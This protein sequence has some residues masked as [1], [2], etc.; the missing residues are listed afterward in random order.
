LASKFQVGSWQVDPAALEITRDEIR[1]KVNPRSMSVLVHLANHAGDVVTNAELLAAFWRGSISSTNAVHKAVAE[2]RAAFGDQRHEA[3][4][5]ETVTK[6]GY[7]LIAPVVF[8]EPVAP[9]EAYLGA[10]GHS[11]TFAPP[12]SKTVWP[13][14]RRAA[15][16][17]MIAVALIGSALTLFYA[18][19]GQTTTGQSASAKHPPNKTLA[20]LRF[21][22]V[23]DS[24][25]NE[26]L[27]EGIATALISR[28]GK[29]PSLTVIDRDRAFLHSIAREPAQAITTALNA[30]YVLD[31][32]VQRL[33]DHL[34]VSVQLYAG[35]TGEKQYAYSN[36]TPLERI[37]T[38]QD[39]VVADVLSE[40]SVHLDDQRRAEMTDWGTKNVKAYLATKEAENLMMRNELR[41]LSYAASRL[42]D[43][44]A[45]DASFV[46][47]YV[48][49]AEALGQYGFE[50]GDQPSL[51]GHHREIVALRQTVSRI[52]PTNDQAVN[53]IRFNETRTGGGQFWAQLEAQARAEIV[54]ETR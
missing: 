51:E 11:A 35:R 37:L 30:Q 54:E 48:D 44:I 3:N 1:V 34:R 43:A 6:K 31:G 52:A 23:D 42:R 19:S 24:P 41:S 40:L 33:N 28:L 12:Q 17:T 21:R 50:T 49:L 22:N 18:G 45:L 32:A 47:A 36:E 38:V 2:L 4:Y 53:A 27:A 14:H 46:N 15:A 5:I 9:A 16:A 39:K 7:R 29:A 13:L 25:D 26:Y 8:L 10:N 20:V